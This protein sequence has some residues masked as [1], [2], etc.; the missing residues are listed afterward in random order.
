MSFLHGVET[1][2]SQKISLVNTVKTA[3]IGLIGTAGSGDINTLKVCATEKDDIQFGSTGT[4]P[5]ALT[6]IRNITRRT[7]ATVMVVSVGD[8]VTTPVAADFVGT[9]DPLTGDRTGLK[10]FDTAL[11]LFGFKPKIFI[12]PGFSSLDGVIAAL[13]STADKFRGCA[14]LDAPVG[15]SVSA[16]IALRNPNALWATNSTR[17]KLFYPGLKDSEGNLH[18]FS[19]FAAA[20]RAL[21]DATAATEG[22]GF[23]VSSSNW[24]ISAVHGLEIPITSSINDITAETNQVNAEGIVTCFNNNGADYREWGNRNASFPTN[25]GPLTFECCQRAK[26]IIDESIELA[27]LPFIDKPIIQAFIDNVRN[28]V[29]RYFNSLIARGAC[30]EGS[31][32]TYDPAKNSPE[33]LA[34]GHIVFTTSYLSPT[35]AERITFDTFIDISLLANLQ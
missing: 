20:N 3:V 34:N 25:T 4:I 14:Y 26:D 32:C 33:E 16:A 12:A 11:P 22:G 1:I 13:I 5:E 15:L 2:T 24:P 31:K 30:L 9:Y 21:V 23:W 17:A 18:P 10:V 7:G 28:T 27:M 19:V 29:N 8:G 35:P 6:I